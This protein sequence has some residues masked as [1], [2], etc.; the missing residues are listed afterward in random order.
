M[1][2]KNG[3]AILT[4]SGKIVDQVTYTNLENGLALIKENKWIISGK[5]SPGYL[6]TVEGVESF[7]KKYLQNKDGLIINEIM[8]N[9]TSY[10]AQNGNEYYDWIELKNNSKKEINLKD[11]YLSTNDNRLTEWKL[12]NIT[13]APG[14]LYI[15]MASGDTNLS[16]K[17][18]QHTNF[19]LSEIESLY[20]TDGK[21]IV[22]SMFISEVPLEYSM[23]RGDNY[24]FS[25]LINQL[26]KRKMVQEYFKWLPKQKLVK[27]QEFIITLMELT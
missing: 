10:L 7:S 1:T 9:N 5:I 8:N 27:Q 2:S 21:N 26:Q 18:Y 15:V 22:D 13:L 23:G 14:E 12:P 3:V 11:Y 6:N 16:N 19:K 20:I 24:G 17:T 25:I 4:K